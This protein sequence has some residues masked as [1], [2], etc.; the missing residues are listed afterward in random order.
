MNHEKMIERLLKIRR[1]I[2]T[3]ESVV[4]TLWVLES[5]ETVVESIDSMLIDL[6]Y[7]SDQG[8]K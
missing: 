3:S 2:E 8:E 1:S 6:G 4:D 5:N 7:D